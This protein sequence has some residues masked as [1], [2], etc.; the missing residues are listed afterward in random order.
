MHVSPAVCGK[1]LKTKLC[2]SFVLSWTLQLLGSLFRRVVGTSLLVDVHYYEGE[3][4]E[5]KIKYM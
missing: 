3:S 4:F 2:F 1:I 5:W